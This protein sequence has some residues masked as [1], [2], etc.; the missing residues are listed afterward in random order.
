MSR[1]GE[2][3]EQDRRG[4]RFSPGRWRAWAPPR[5]CFP[6]RGAGAR[7][8]RTAKT[9]PAKGPILYRRNAETERY[10]RTLYQ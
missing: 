1:D 6:A 9:A 7:R 3:Q 10:Y 2:S 4:A 8:S 5:R